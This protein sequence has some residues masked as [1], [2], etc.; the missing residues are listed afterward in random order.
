VHQKKAGKIAKNKDE[1]Y[2]LYKQAQKNKR[3]S[4]LNARVTI[5]NEVISTVW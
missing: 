2:E 3:L 1:F 4:P 5:S